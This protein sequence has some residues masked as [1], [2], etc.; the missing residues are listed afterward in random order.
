[1]QVTGN[2]DCKR[3]ICIR[4]A[5]N[6]Q[7]PVDVRMV[8]LS[9]FTSTMYVQLFSCSSAHA[10]RSRRKGRSVADQ[11]DVPIAWIRW[12]KKLGIRPIPPLPRRRFPDGSLGPEPGRFFGR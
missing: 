1:M 10:G 2:G 4:W 5:R 12:H 9:P 6:A 11:S 7:M 3:F 8:I